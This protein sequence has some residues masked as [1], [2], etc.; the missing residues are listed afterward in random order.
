MKLKRYSFTQLVEAFLLLASIAYTVAYFTVAF[1]RM[2][3]PYDLEWIEGGI[4]CNVHRLVEGKPLYTAPSS[5]FYSLPYTPFFYYVMWALSGLFGLHYWV[6]RL[7]SILASLCIGLLLSRVTYRQARSCFLAVLVPGLFYASFY[8]TGCFFDLARLDSLAYALA[9]GALYVAWYF[10]SLWGVFLGSVLLCLAIFTKQTVMPFIAF[11][12]LFLLPKGRRPAF[13]FGTA[14]V[15]LVAVCLGWLTFS[16]GG[17]FYKLCVELSAGAVYNFRFGAREVLSNFLFKTPLI[18]VGVLCWF[19]LFLCAHRRGNPYAGGCSAWGWPFAAG[20]LVFFLA[21]S[22]YSGWRN[23]S[24]PMVLFG[25][26]FVS[27]FWG[28]VRQ[29]KEIREKVVNRV[30]LAAAGLQ[31]VLFSYAP[32]QQIPSTADREAGDYF[33]EKMGQFEGEISIIFHPYYPVILGKRPSFH[34][35]ELFAYYVRGRRD[36]DKAELPKDLIERIEGRYYDAIVLDYDRADMGQVSG[37][38]LIEVGK[39]RRLIDEH[40]SLT[41]R[42]FDEKDPRFWTPAGW[43]VR[44]DFLYLPRRTSSP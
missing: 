39:L 41:E 5:E 15:I 21:R 32:L 44:P 9:L 2:S 36:P 12:V 6:G 10:P 23:D 3:Y 1:S 24:I 7:I 38:D 31:F 16:S 11:G 30:L 33:M 35:D 43:Q 20:F 13:V 18:S 26:L 37:T 17:W 29:Q 19:I 34:A 22:G 14:S 42:L 25:L 27:V 28:C 40:Y 8:Y 4:A